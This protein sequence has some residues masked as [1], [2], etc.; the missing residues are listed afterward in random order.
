MTINI[1]RP[2]V[3][4]SLL[5]AG[6]LAAGLLALVG[7]T[8]AWAAQ[9]NFAPAQNFPVGSSPTTVTNA[10][11]NGDGKVDLAAQ[12]YTSDSVSVL[13]GNGNG[14]YQP[15]TD[16]TVGDGPTAVISGQF[17]DDNAD[18]K[19]DS[20][21]FVDLA[22]A[23]QNSDNVSVL[24]GNGNGTYQPKTNFAVG[25]GP[26]SNLPDPISIIGAD[27]NGDGKADL[28][29]ANSAY[30]SV[31][32]GN[33]EGSFQAAQSFDI[34]PNSNQIITADFNGDG[35]ADLATTDL[36][37]EL[38]CCPGGVSVFLG[39]GDGTFQNP[40]RP[41]RL[42][43]AFS[44]NSGDYN[45]D[46][47]ADLAATGYLTSG[48]VSVALG[49]GDGS[50]QAQQDFAV[51]ATPT[52]VT[53]ADLDGDSYDD[54]AVSNH[55]SDNVSVL[56]SNGNGTFQDKQNFAAGDGPIFVIGADVNADRYAD[57]A[58]V[59]EISN[60]VSVL[61]NN[62]PPNTTIDS[63]PTGTIT[64][65]SA[66]FSFSSSEASSSFECSLDGAP[67]ASCTSPKS[68]PNEGLL[69]DGS[70]TFK[71]RATNAAG[72]TDPTPASSTWKV[73]TLAPTV[74]SVSPADG[75][76]DVALT[77]HAEVTFSEDVDQSTITDQTFTLTKQNFSSP[78]AAHVTYDSA[79]KK[80]TLDPTVGLEANISYRATIKG[81][82]N[83]VKDAAGHVLSADKT[84][85]FS[86]VDTIVPSVPVIT[87][88]PNNSI[89]GDG[90]FIISGTAEANS[91]VE[92]FEGSVSRG[93]ATAD[94]S[95]NWGVS[96]TGVGEGSHA[97]TAKAR[98]AAGNTS[99]PSNALTV[100]VEIP[101]LVIGVSPAD[102]SQNVALSTSVEATFSEAMDTS[103]LTTSTFTLTKQNSSI[104]K[105]A[106]ISYSSTTNKATLDPSSDLDSNTTYTARVEGGSAGVKDSA[107]N[108]LAQDRTWTFTTAAPPAPTCT[109]I[110]TANADTI[111]GTSGDDVICARGGND[112]IKG[113]GG[114]DILKGE[115]GNDTLL[116]GVGNDTLEG[117]LGTDTASYSASLTAVSA[118]LAT[119]SST[120]EGSDKFVDVENL[121]GTS[122]ADTLTGSGTNN[123]LTGGGGNDTEQGGLG[124]DTVVGSGGADTLK[125]EGGAD[126]VNSKDG[127]NGN[128]SLDG[129]SGTDTKVTDTTEK[130]IVGFP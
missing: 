37:T 35:K 108:A 55:E 111:S 30:V 48:K 68:V 67:F 20:A 93:R 53:S 100:D 80:A 128:D 129:G 101:P 64:S 42:A 95:G 50:F 87:S 32:L 60:N 2:R 72:N 83:G 92:L 99:D 126:T 107:G 110:G 120:G 90:N 62:R 74:S 54:L 61:L 63:G 14:T 119:N 113:L 9:P 71:V 8:P 49:K 109:K 96:L 94:G 34:L 125:G 112:T 41:L 36:G 88:P 10:D 4:L 65:G 69:A 82:S 116:G 31:L 28:A 98:D 102:S 56:F 81:G 13:L 26:N 12:N 11:F 121:L 91:T 45:G 58:V 3:L 130:S 23:N 5:V 15:K 21:D 27:F 59:N 24:L 70:H 16:L 7:T 29:V 97:Y 86:T 43:L 114:N 103:T 25:A 84:W 105:T 40:R 52:A 115:S 17:N 85:T 79:N 106:V 33:G 122:K 89:D 22:V 1:Y 127:V 75:E 104:P 66:S 76:T 6:V 44:V 47:K 18:G 39:N 123:K 117:G 38:A 73:D 51:G 78:V 57:L 118:S 46:G 19:A 124:N 77:A